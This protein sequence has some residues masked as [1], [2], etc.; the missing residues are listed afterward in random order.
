MPSAWIF[1]GWNRRSGAAAGVSVASLVQTQV[2]WQGFQPNTLGGKPA[3]K[4]ETT[5]RAGL[6]PGAAAQSRYLSNSS[7][8][9]AKTNRN[10]TNSAAVTTIRMKQMRRTMGFIGCQT[11]RM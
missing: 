9:M 8:K 3:L 6:F 4:E 2:S 10:R 1:E 5:G 11:R 7:Q